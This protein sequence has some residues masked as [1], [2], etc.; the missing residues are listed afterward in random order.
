MEPSHRRDRESD[1]FEARINARARD[2][3]S[4]SPYFA[5]GRVVTSYQHGIL[6]L[7]GCPPS[8]YLKQVAQELVSRI[9]GVNAVVNLIEV[10]VAADRGQSG[11]GAH[12][13][14]PDVGPA[15]SARERGESTR[16][17]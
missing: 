7:R 4:C 13:T 12:W 2:R 9:E 14:L 5:L 3:L 6:M 8:Q 17:G 1:E 10:R 11:M 16:E 15:P